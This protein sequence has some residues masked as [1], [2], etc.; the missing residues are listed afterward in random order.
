MLR[1]ATPCAC[2]QVGW[3]IANAKEERRA[4]CVEEAAYLATLAKARSLV[5][6]PSAHEAAYLATLAE[7]PRSK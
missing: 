5:I 2:T 1:P 4:P 6:T 3:A 7:V